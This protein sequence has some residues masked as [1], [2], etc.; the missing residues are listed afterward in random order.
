MGNAIEFIEEVSRVL[1]ASPECALLSDGSQTEVRRIAGGNLFTTRLELIV[2]DLEGAFEWIP[3][4]VRLEAD[5]NAPGVQWWINTEVAET[6]RTVRDLERHVR[7][8]E[9]LLRIAHAVQRIA[10][11]I[12]RRRKS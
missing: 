9:R 2:D 10:E 6:P 5:G 11:E 3:S 4:R 12:T 8:H 1:L 7:A